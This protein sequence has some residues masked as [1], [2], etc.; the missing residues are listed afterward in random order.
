VRGVVEGVESMMFFDTGA[1]LNVVDE[2]FIDELKR[3]NPCLQITRANTSIRC[4]NDSKMKGLG[5]VSLDI[6]IS[7]IWTRQIFTVVQGLFPKI[8]I[9]IRQMKKSNIVV[10]PRN[11]CIWI[12]DKRAPFV[13]SVRPLEE[14]ENGNQLA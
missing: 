2:K 8:I 3:K 7:G 4:A 9:G 13:S 11:D 14:Q 10:D 1:E 12:E 5:N 6:N